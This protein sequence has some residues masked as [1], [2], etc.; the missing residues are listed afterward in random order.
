MKFPGCL[1]II[2]CCLASGAHAAAYKCK[3]AS[4]KVT[5]SDSPC[6]D[7]KQKGDKLF[8]R[9]AGYNPLN[10]D[11]RRS[12][13]AAVTRTCLMR[14][15]QTTAG[16]AQWRSYCDCSATEAAKTVSIEELR[17]MAAN[18]KNKAM[19]GRMTQLGQ[20]AGKVCANHLANPPAPTPRKPPV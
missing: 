8:D 1:L 13:I 18:P 7:L 15:S 6:A 12:F 4:G 10:E 17:S 20:E 5:Y 9:G 14:R 3:D 16:E 2:A 19:E 11:E